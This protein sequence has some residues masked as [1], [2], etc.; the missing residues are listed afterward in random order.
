[1]AFDIFLLAQSTKIVSMEKTSK[2]T[3]N[4]KDAY[5]NYQTLKSI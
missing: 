1:M 3:D 4:S 2:Q 5:G